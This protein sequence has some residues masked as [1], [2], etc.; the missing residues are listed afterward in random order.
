MN[1]GFF[2]LYL[3]LSNKAKN[4]NNKQKEKKK[5]PNCKEFVANKYFRSGNF[6][7]KSISSLDQG[8]H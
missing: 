3:A 7:K 2:L 4:K 8:N 1:K 6:G 5:P